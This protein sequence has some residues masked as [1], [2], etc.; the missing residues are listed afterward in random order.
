L[1]VLGLPGG[2]CRAPMGPEPEWLADG[3]RKVLSNLGRPGF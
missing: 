1:R 3:A 2:A